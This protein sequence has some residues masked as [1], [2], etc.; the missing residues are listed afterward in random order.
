MKF[1]LVIL[2]ILLYCNP[3]Q[4]IKHSEQNK[5]MPI[6]N[7]NS[8]MEENKIRMLVEYQYNLSCTEDSKSKILISYLRQNLIFQATNILSDEKTEIINRENL[9]LILKEE[10]LNKSGI[11]KNRKNSQLNLQSPDQIF[12]YNDHIQC[13]KNNRYTVFSRMYTINITN[14]REFPHKLMVISEYELTRQNQIYQLN[15][16]LKEIQ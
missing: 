12:V 15:S 8:Q 13:N 6:Q 14:G 10:Y 5:T 4:N 2:S 1:K 11:I 3:N 7:Q 16:Y 9:D